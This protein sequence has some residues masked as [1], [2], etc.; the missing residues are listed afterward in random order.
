MASSFVRAQ[1]L[2]AEA[3]ATLLSEDEMVQRR[4]LSEVEASGEALVAERRAELDR[5]AEE[6]GAEEASVEAR[7]RA[8]LAELGEPMPFGWLRGRVG[9]RRKWR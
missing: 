5:Q 8:S 2:E 6:L 7:S 3:M 1:R 9:L 4:R